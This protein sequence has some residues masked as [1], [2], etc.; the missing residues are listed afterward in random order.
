MDEGISLS[1]RLRRSL[2]VGLSR[3]R[4]SGKAENKML[5]AFC[6]E[7]FRDLFP[8]LTPMDVKVPVAA[9]GY[10]ELLCLR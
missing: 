3:G 6:L 4:I 7:P 2:G 1:E 5:E 9:N 8:P 10:F